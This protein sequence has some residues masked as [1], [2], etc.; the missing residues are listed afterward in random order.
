LFHH[1]NPRFVAPG[2][3]R[4]AARMQDIAVDGWA[5]TLL[6]RR[7]VGYAS[8]CQTVGMNLGYFTSITVFLAFNDPD[9]CNRYLRP[10][11]AASTVGAITLAGYLR[12]WAVVYVVVTAAVALFKRE[13]PPPLQ[14]TASLCVASTPPW[15]TMRPSV[16]AHMHSLQVLQAHADA[17]E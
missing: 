14:S 9:F 8:T 15:S 3:T 13:R 17:V 5:L 12:L 11:A 10:A 2:V 16:A 4:L 7:H 6:S 1:L